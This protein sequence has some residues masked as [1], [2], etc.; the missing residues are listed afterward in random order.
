MKNVAVLCMVVATLSAGLSSDVQLLESTSEWTHQEAIA[1]TLTAKGFVISPKL[2]DAITGIVRE[3][4]AKSEF[5]PTSGATA[6][7]ERKVTQ[8][9]DYDSIAQK[10]IPSD[11]C[12][13]ELQQYHG[14]KKGPKIKVQ[15]RVCDEDSL[16]AWA[17]GGKMEQEYRSAIFYSPRVE[18]G[19]KCPADHDKFGSYSGLQNICPMWSQV[20]KPQSL[21]IPKLDAWKA[22]SANDVL[23]EAQTWCTHASV[24]P[25]KEDARGRTATRL[26]GTGCFGDKFRVGGAPERPLQK[27]SRRDHEFSYGAYGY[28]DIANGATSL[29]CR[30]LC[31]DA[32]HGLSNACSQCHDGEQVNAFYDRKTR[33]SV[34]KVFMGF[35]T[36]L[37]QMEGFFCGFVYKNNDKTP[38]WA[39]MKSPFLRSRLYR[40]SNKKIKCCGT[41]DD[42]GNIR[43]NKP[44]ECRPCCGSKM[45]PCEGMTMQDYAGDACM[46]W[47]RSYPE[48]GQVNPCTAEEVGEI[49]R[50]RR[51][52]RKW[53]LSK[54]SNKIRK[55]AT[56]AVKGI[57]K[58]VGK[59]ATGVMKKARNMIGKKIMT[60]FTRIAKKY[61]FPETWHML[62]DFVE[63]MMMGSKKKQK[64]ALKVL[65]K[66]LKKGSLA[67]TVGR[68]IGPLFF[69]TILSRTQS[70]LKK[71]R[72][73]IKK[74]L[75]PKSGKEN[76]PPI[77][78]PAPV[79]KTFL[80]REESME[81]EQLV[82]QIK[83]YCV[84]ASGGIELQAPTF[85][86]S[87]QTYDAWGPG[88]FLDNIQGNKKGKTMESWTIFAV[89]AQPDWW[90][91]AAREHSTV[92][93]CKL[94]R[95]KCEQLVYPEA[96]QLALW[97]PWIC[98]SQ[99][100]NECPM[101]P[102]SN[103]ELEGT[104]SEYSYPPDLGGPLS[105]LAEKRF[106]SEDYC[107][108]GKK[109][110][111]TSKAK[112]CGPQCV[113]R[114]S[115]RMKACNT[116]CCQGGYMAAG[117]ET[118]LIGD[119]GRSL[120]GIWMGT[121][122]AL[123]R[124]FMACYRNLVMTLRFRAPCLEPF[125]N[126]DPTSG[127]KN[128]LGS[129]NAAEQGRRGGRGFGTTGSFNF[130]SGSGNRAGNSERF[131]LKEGAQQAD[132][133]KQGAQEANLDKV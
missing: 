45:Y 29:V 59:V 53:G 42:D 121:V 21:C 63:A 37:Q 4:V 36:L 52:R 130:N 111:E 101:A 9:G 31:F 79:L 12:S 26:K 125:E 14:S 50:R 13:T 87:V 98:I 40:K 120:C 89:K 57:R 100:S 108:I 5:K 75:H 118:T 92:R 35:M 17:Q 7:G 103:P 1:D 84:A 10:P 47:L 124:T 56:G 116:C 51:R 83:S 69:F 32:K 70:G 99:M 64:A 95:G 90:I 62:K 28:E 38:K 65:L 126:Q 44:R 25:Y 119:D 131:L 66:N 27:W 128:R 123:I 20:A 82:A 85:P 97:A 104:P 22:T 23:K 61:F 105:K 8:T 80:M 113:A 60:K 115:L 54:A 91:K 81:M 107:A 132:L 110:T 6:N 34:L 46:N 122:D 72:R 133:R 129:G 76:R 88:G 67:T 93:K 41:L 43:K 55:V 15:M 78:V 39:I 114:I 16:K 68:E 33:F 73:S 18:L 102:T 109:K 127:S 71:T 48:A 77:P 2:L 24:A 86:V 117:V 112:F 11:N 30:G 19:S 94:E 49:W 74:G 58:K 3:E 96:S 106:E